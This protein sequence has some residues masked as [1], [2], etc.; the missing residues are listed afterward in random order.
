VTPVSPVLSRPLTADFVQVTWAKNQS[1]YHILPSIR[2]VMEGQCGRVTTRWRLTW[3]ERWKLLFHGQLFLQVL[4]FGDP[5]Y[6]VKPMVDEPSI[7]ECL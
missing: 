4:T 7:E 6:P 3:R 1:E 2:S 5:L